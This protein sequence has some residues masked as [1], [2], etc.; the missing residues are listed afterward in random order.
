MAR[1]FKTDGDR[2]TLDELRSDIY[3]DLLTGTT[4]SSGGKGRAMV[5][6]VVDLQP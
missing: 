4:S 5:D 2:R 1:S 3:L 6:I